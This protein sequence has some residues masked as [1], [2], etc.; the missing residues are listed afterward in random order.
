MKTMKKP[1]LK[2]S[3]I[4]YL[5]L[6]DNMRFLSFQSFEFLYLKESLKPSLSKFSYN[7]I[8]NNN[9]KFVD[10]LLIIKLL[11]T[12]LYLI[13][14]KKYRLGFLKENNYSQILNLF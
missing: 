2:L 14:R 4:I 7:S 6:Y 1:F 5:I 11:V 10:N 9:P 13:E 12:L 8:T 3:I